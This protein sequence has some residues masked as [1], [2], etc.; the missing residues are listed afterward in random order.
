MGDNIELYS[1]RQVK[2]QNCLYQLL[3]EQRKNVLFVGEGNFTFTLAFAAL[4]KY[5]W[6]SNPIQLDDWQGIVPTRYELTPGLSLVILQNLYGMHSFGVGVL[7]APVP[8]VVRQTCIANLCF[9]LGQS[10]GDYQSCLK[11]LESF[12][13]C[14][15]E[16]HFGIN[17]C[18][19]PL[20]LIRHNCVIWFQCP[21]SLDPGQ[22][23]YDFLINTAPKL[24]HDSYVCVGI[25]KRPNYVLSYKLESILDSS[26]MTSA[27]VL[28]NYE[29]LGADDDLIYKI[30]EFGYC[31]QSFIRDIHHFIRDFHLTLIFRRRPPPPQCLIVK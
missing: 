19:I 12:S 31:H 21:W 22:L 26:Q 7:D 17:A 23:I 25:T 10:H 16:C 9:P 1:G 24:V 18:D 27:E 6:I 28:K 20:R 29:F 3:I 8:E 4:R 14:L 13:P 30:L 15:P 11:I 5:C 2:R